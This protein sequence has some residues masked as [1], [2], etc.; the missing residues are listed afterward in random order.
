MRVRVRVWVWG[1]VGL[2]G[3]LAVW[4]GLGLRVWVC[5]CVEAVAGV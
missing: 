5:G 2:C 4:L 3:D 1:R